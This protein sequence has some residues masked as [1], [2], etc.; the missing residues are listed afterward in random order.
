[1]PTAEGAR[2][3]MENCRRG[4]D[5]EMTDCRPELNENGY[6]TRENVCF[7]IDDEPFKQNMVNNDQPIIA[8]VKSVPSSVYDLPL[9][10]SQ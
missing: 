6:F 8:D 1:V 4:G 2:W 3:I 9:T 10:D 7:D 5:D